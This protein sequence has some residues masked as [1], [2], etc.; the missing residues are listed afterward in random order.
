MA[1]RYVSAFKRAP[2]RAWVMEL[3]PTCEQPPSWPDSLDWQTWRPQCELTVD[4]IEAFLGGDSIDP[5]KG[6]ATHF[7][8]PDLQVDLARA[9]RAG[10]RVIEC[11]TATR[12]YAEQR[13]AIDAQIARGGR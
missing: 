11:G 9:A 8:A 1:R 4:R 3:E 10:W 6:R 5:C 2:A 7:G 12:F 13:G